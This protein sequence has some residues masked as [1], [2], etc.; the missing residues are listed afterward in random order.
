MPI[1]W[2]GALSFDILEVVLPLTENV[3]IALAPAF[4]DIVYAALVIA[5]EVLIYFELFISSWTV[6]L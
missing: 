4:W 6:M 1:I 3:I 5:S 2:T